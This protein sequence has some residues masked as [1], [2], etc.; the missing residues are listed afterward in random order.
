MLRNL[1]QMSSVV[2]VCSNLLWGP[3]FCE[4][5]L[6]LTLLTLF[7]VI[8]LIQVVIQSKWVSSP[9]TRAWKCLQSSLGG[10]R[11]RTTKTKKQFIGINIRLTF[12][13]FQ[14]SELLPLFAWWSLFCKP[15]SHL[16]YLFFVVSGRKLNLDHVT[17]NWLCSIS[18]KL[19]L[20]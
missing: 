4:L 20:I 18:L 12:I 9:C 10:W 14:L 5:Y 13:A 19:L 3:L 1:L 6:P 8:S 16:L 7:S 2:S 17:S 15:F 11:G